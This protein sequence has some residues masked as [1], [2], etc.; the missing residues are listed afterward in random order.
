MSL[1]LPEVF[2]GEKVCLPNDA[3]QCYQQ[4]SENNH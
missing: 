1:I 4:L 2:D 3:N